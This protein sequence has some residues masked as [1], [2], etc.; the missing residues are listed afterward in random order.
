M[1]RLKVNVLHTVHADDSFQFLYGSIK[2]F[3]TMRKDTG[4]I[5]FNSSMVRLKEIPAGILKMHNQ[6]FQFLYGS[7]KSNV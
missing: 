6:K 4:E 1:V 5:Y 7:I 2:S 3:A